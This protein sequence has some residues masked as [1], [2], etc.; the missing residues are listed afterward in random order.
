[1]S[2]TSIRRILHDLNFHLYKIAVVQELLLQ[3]FVR[4]SAFCRTMLQMMEEDP[5]IVILTSDEAHFHLNGSVNKQ[6]CRYWSQINPE[7]L[8]QRSLHSEKVTV[9]AGVA[10]FGVIGPYF[11]E[12]N[13]RVV[14]VNVERYVTMVR[15]FLVPELRRRRIARRTV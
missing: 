2:N 6:N 13:E 1:M 11:F 7:N 4:R 5:D 9:W 3:D 15:E 14:T 10:K 12:Q 8:H